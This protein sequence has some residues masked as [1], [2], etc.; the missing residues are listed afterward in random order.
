MK[1]LGWTVTCDKEIE[2]ALQPVYNR[3]GWSSLIREPWTGAWQRN[4]RTYQCR[5]GADRFRRFSLTA[6]RFDIAKMRV[7]LVRL[8]EAGVWEETGTAFS[9]VLRKPN[10]WQTYFSPLKLGR[11]QTGF[12]HILKEAMLAMS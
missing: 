12:G 3:E 4:V 10:R 11:G 8:T 6:D 7:K 2:K 1:L 9:A 5:Y